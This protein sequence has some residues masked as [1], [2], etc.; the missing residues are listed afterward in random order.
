M[1]DVCKTNIFIFFQEEFHGLK[2]Q[3]YFE[4]LLQS[5]RYGPVQTNSVN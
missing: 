3:R 5:C 1:K 4:S 2:Y